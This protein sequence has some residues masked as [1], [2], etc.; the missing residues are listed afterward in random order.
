M[1]LEW[2]KRGLKKK[3]KTHQGL[4]ARMGVDR[5]AVT[6]MLQG[7]RKILAD[8]LQAIA[9]Y[10]EE[11]IPVTGGGPLGKSGTKLDDDQYA[12][13]TA[14]AS[15][16]VWR[17]AGGL[18]M[19]AATMESVRA[20]PDHRVAG[21]KQ[22]SVRIEGTD[23]NKLFAFGDIVIFVP[24]SAV[25]AAPRE[26][27]IVEIERRKGD[28]VETTIRRVHLEDGVIEFWPESTDPKWQE[29]FRVTDIHKI[30]DFKIVG[31]YLAAQRVNPD[32]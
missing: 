11:P 24:F 5:T 31:L 17:E 10:I 19:L 32:F 28:L 3:D 12:P 16:G 27:D 4:A 7:K 22:H 25:R 2:L 29:P 23:C 8:E 21:L 15:G 6:K 20:Y 30:T 26:G 14:I 1:Y 18:S 9:D 13:L